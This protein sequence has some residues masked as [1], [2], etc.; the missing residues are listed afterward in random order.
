MLFFCQWQRECSWVV[1]LPTIEE[2]AAAAKERTG[3]VPRR[4]F[5]VPVGVVS[6]EVSLVES[7]EPGEAGLFVVDA[8]FDE[9]AAELFAAWEAEPTAE[10]EPAPVRCS[11]EADDDNDASYRCALPEGHAGEHAAGGLVWK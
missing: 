4:I 7:D 1:D 11:S 10:T 8:V 3:I 2:A 5:P 6:F 9:A